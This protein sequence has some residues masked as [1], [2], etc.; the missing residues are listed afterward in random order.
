MDD[1]I[2]V[3]YRIVKKVSENYCHDLTHVTLRRD[4]LVGESPGGLR[5]G[6]RAPQYGANIGRVPWP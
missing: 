2:F 4:P 6:K 1:T 3:V 5:T